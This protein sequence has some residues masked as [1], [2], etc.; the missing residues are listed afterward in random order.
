MGWMI[1]ALGM[2]FMLVTGHVV[3]SLR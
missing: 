3:E 1:M 2:V